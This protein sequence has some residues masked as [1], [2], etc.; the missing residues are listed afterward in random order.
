MSV[1]RE[2]RVQGCV[3]S[4]VACVSITSLHDNSYLTIL[5]YLTIEGVKARSA[6]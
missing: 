3:V 5:T 6:H 2:K 1:G 4:G